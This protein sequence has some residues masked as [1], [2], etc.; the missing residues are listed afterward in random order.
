MTKNVEGACP[1][2][3]SDTKRFAAE[4]MTDSKGSQQGTVTLYR[5]PRPFGKGKTSEKRHE[6]KIK[7]GGKRWNGDC[8]KVL[9]LH[10]H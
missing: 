10:V 5:M 7:S 4:N 8:L 3:K 2:Y 1:T 6:I 9:L